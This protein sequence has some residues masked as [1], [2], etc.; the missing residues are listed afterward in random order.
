[1]TPSG[2]VLQGPFGLPFISTTTGAGPQT[3]TVYM[4]QLD[5][6]NNN[7]FSINQQ[8]AGGL[9]VTVSLG[10]TAPNIGTVPSSVTING[11]SDSVDAQFNPLNTGQTLISVVTPSGYTT[12]GNKFQITAQV[13]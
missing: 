13:Q 12:S 7:N 4:A 10:N 6:T 3:F 1:M 8:L 5:P 9:S 11:G 2:V